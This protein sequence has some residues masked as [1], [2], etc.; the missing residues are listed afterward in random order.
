VTTS[1]EDMSATLERFIAAENAHDA[2]AM[3]ECFVEDGWLLN[4]PMGVKVE[5]RR[6]LLASWEQTFA[7]NAAL[8]VDIEGIAFG[9]DLCTYW[10][11][12]R[13]DVQAGFA[14][15]DVANPGP[16]EA[17]G[18]AILDFRDGLI[19]SERYFSDIVTWGRI[20]GVSI[21]AL[22]GHVP[23][24]AATLFRS[25]GPPRLDPAPGDERAARYRRTLEA[26]ISAENAHDI[27][28]LAHLFHPDATFD[29][30]TFDVHHDGREAIRAQFEQTIR[31]NPYFHVELDGAAYGDGVCVYWGTGRGLVSEG[32]LGLDPER[33][34]VHDAFGLS[35]LYIDQEGLITREVAFSDFA[36]VGREAGVPV[37]SILAA[38][39]GT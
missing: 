21:D 6:A 18:A 4:I 36:A 12:G 34:G 25:D 31:S 9:R 1:T 14:G 5:G 16:V 27:D 17:F 13:L 10:G 3:A 15:L 20:A 39:T 7:A 24:G 32:Y 29:G 11:T 22:V 2:Q 35:L 38:I 26:F 30:P 28:A 19:V 23:L 8:Q 37:D 33:P